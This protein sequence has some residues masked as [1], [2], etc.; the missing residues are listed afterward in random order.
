[1]RPVSRRP[2]PV[3]HNPASNRWAQFARQRLRLLL[4]LPSVVLLALSLAAAQSSNVQSLV[5]SG[6]AALDAGQFDRATADFEKARELAP[7]SLEVN[8]GLLLSYLQSARLAEA[9]TLGR[10]AVGRWPQDAQLQHW[11][12][13]VYF[14]QGQNAEALESLRRSEKLDSAQFGIHFDIALVLLTQ[15]QYPPAA[16]ELEKALSLE[17]SNALAHVLLGR[18]YQ[19]SNRTLQAIEQFQTAL[20]LDPRLPLGHFH[21]GFAYG[22]LGRNQEA[23]AEYEKELAAGGTRNPEVLYE[24]GH[25]LLETGDW[26]PAITHLKRATE[27][28]P[29]NAD[30][31]YDLGKGLLLV[32]EAEAAIAALRRSIELKPTDPSP[33]YQLARALEKIGQGEEARQERQRFAELKKAQPQTG[34]MA[35]GRVQ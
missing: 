16:D 30:A 10:T 9:A 11:L 35:T 23:I 26:K 5:R 28:A 19:N 34:G 29:Q 21:L 17:P 6:Q 3:A 15:K 33:H 14:K 7:D 1:M 4:L 32:G 27:L 22:S 12:G 8:R 20:R 2:F 25:C 31:F 13:L 24:L 18:A